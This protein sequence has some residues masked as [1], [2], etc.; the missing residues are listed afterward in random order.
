[1]AILLPFYEANKDLER[2]TV[3]HLAAKAGARDCSLHLLERKDTHVNEVDAAGRSPLFC[4]VHHES[5][6]VEMLLKRGSNPNA[7]TL[8]TRREKGASALHHLVQ[9]PRFSRLAKA[10]VS[11]LQDGDFLHKLRLLLEAGA[12]V[13]HVLTDGHSAMSL[14]CCHAVNLVGSHQK[15]HEA[16]SGLTEVIT[17]TIRE[18]IAILLDH[19]AALDI[20][21]GLNAFRVLVA[22]AKKS[23]ARVHHS[24]MMRSQEQKQSVLRG[25]TTVL[26]LA[27]DMADVMTS[28]PATALQINDLRFTLST[29]TQGAGFG[30]RRADSK[31]LDWTDFESLFS[32]I[33]TKAILSTDFKTGFYVIEDQDDF[34]DLASFPTALE[35]TMAVLP[36]HMYG[37][38]VHRLEAIS[39]NQNN[40]DTSA[41]KLFVSQLA[42][43]VMS[44]KGISR[45]IIFHQ[46][47]IPR[48]QSVKNL[49]LP[50]AMKKYLTL[51]D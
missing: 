10:N 17:R 31:D 41:T 2:Q 5:R 15:N 45:C 51:C 6:L 48:V 28:H 34:V 43:E 8:S 30:I 3:L 49:V 37:D 21:H 19:G 44:L 13:N 22:E 4:A 38:V 32:D 50:E 27:R 46:L 47:R 20:K 1:M 33:A 23:F 26:R 11:A 35:K 9:L 24:Y 39:E 14:L 42:S 12:N 36:S 18:G 16:S 25:V 29:K 7:L 40:I